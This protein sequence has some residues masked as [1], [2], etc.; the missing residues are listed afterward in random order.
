MS[1]HLDR[2]RK[3]SAWWFLL[4]IFFTI[5]GGIIAYFAIRSDDSRRANDCLLLGIIL[6]AIP[7]AILG[8][9]VAF[10]SVSLSEL[11]PIFY[12]PIYEI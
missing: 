8:I 5:I 12:P 4:P 6:F 1:E 7:L 9:M 10:F 2:Y 3:R 11:E